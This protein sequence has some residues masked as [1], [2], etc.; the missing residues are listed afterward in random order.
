MRQRRP[1][2]IRLPLRR[3]PF[4]KSRIQ[5]GRQKIRQKELRHG[6]PQ[7]S[8]DLGQHRLQRVAAGGGIGRPAQPLRSAPS[9]N[10]RLTAVTK[11]AP[12]PSG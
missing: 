5:T 1:M 12:S 4:Q 6:V 3:V 7:H 8:G 9:A 11:A 10:S 2:V